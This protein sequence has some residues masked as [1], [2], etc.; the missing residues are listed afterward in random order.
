M[1]RNLDQNR[2]Y[3]G[4]KDQEKRLVAFFKEMKV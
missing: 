1:G 4:I 3:N 2:F